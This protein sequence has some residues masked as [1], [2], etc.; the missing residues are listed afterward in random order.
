MAVEA[1]DKVFD[2]NGDFLA[3]QS[4]HYELGTVR[5]CFLVAVEVAVGGNGA[6]TTT[7][8]PTPINTFQA[9][10]LHE[11]RERVNFRIRQP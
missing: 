11:K 8:K 7:N 4:G 1:A 10:E 9:G 2:G 3:V 5:A 6:P